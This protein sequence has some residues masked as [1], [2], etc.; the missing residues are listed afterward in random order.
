MNRIQLLGTVTP[1]ER[2]K[3]L[4]DCTAQQNTERIPQIDF[5]RNA[6]RIYKRDETLHRRPF[7]GSYISFWGRSREALHS[8]LKGHFRNRS[9]KNYT[10]SRR[11][12]N[13]SLRPISKDFSFTVEKGRYT[14]RRGKTSQRPSLTSDFSVYRK[15]IQ[16]R[17]GRGAHSNKYWVPFC[18]WSLFSNISGYICYVRV[19]PRRE[20]KLDHK[21][22]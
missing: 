19:R 17:R 1:L 12:K 2:E 8:G 22:F 15:S 16:L 10:F 3:E 14:W 6:Q 5:L 20:K 13:L 4:L 21:E 9:V 11:E 7:L 18:P